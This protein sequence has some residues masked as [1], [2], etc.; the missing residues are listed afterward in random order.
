M[1]IG[2]I[3]LDGDFGARALLFLHGG[4]LG[5]THEVS[6]DATFGRIFRFEPGRREPVRTERI[7]GCGFQQATA[8]PD[9]LYVAAI[10]DEQSQA[11]LSFGALTVC[12]AVVLQTETLQVRATIALSKHTTWHSLALWHGK[13]QLRAAA[14][15][16]SPV[17]KVYFASDSVSLRAR[18][19]GP[20]LALTAGPSRASRSSCSLRNS[21]SNLLQ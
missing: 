19:L 7:S 14:S 1:T 9:Q 12:D 16:E 15:D 2:E 4:V 20:M 11:E 5:F 13:G 18:E 10:C 3:S 6:Q 17:V 21:K 8:S